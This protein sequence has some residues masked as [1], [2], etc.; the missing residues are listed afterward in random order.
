M[1]QTLISLTYMSLHSV[2]VKLFG[3]ASSTFNVYIIYLTI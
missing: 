2:H 3:F 1:Y